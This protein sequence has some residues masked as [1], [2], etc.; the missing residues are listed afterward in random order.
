MHRAAAKLAPVALSFLMLA[1]CSEADSIVPGNAEDPRPFS[2]IGADEEMRFTGTEPFWGGSV[3][4]ESLTYSTPDNIDGTAIAVSRFAGRGG[5]TWSGTL[6]GE[7]FD[8]MVTP[9][10]CSD[11]MSDKT[12]PFVATLQLGAQQR[13]GCAWRATHPPADP[14]QEPARQPA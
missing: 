13:E 5:V 3:V 8:L 9:G 10:R 7:S 1:A 2:E 4:G 14:A 11:G 12:Y 6:D